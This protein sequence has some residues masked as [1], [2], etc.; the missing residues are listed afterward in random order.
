MEFQVAGLKARDLKYQSS[1]IPS[2][3]REIGNNGKER[4]EPLYDSGCRVYSIY[5]FGFSF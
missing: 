5:G 2:T 3:S 4:W 1:P